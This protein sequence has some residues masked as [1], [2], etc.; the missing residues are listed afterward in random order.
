MYASP[1]WYQGAIARKDD[2]VVPWARIRM[3]NLFICAERT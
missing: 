1:I 3:M 2:R